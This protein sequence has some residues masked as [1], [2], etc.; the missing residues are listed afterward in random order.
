MFTIR[1][2]QP[3]DYK[4]VYQVISKAFKTAAYSDGQEADLVNKLRASSSFVPELSLVAV[5]NGDIVGHILF[6]KALVGQQIVLAL[7]PLSVLPCYQ[8]QGIGQ[9]LINEGHKIAQKL[10]YKYSVVLGHAEY[11]PKTGYVPASYYGIKAPFEVN[12]ANFMAIC[13][14]KSAPQINGILK[15]DKTFGIV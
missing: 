9:A 2:E 1:T 8:N 6:T 14:D 3:A 12:D 15:Y 10:G 5:V 11:Y 13:L 7:A 4:K